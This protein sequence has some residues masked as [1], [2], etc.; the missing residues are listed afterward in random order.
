MARVLIVD[1]SA[2]AR[3]RLA[4]VLK[5]DGHEVIEADSGTAALK[6]LKEI[7]PDLVTV[8]LLMP[9]MDGLELIRKIRETD[10]DLP[11]AVISAD[12]QKA[13][14]EEVAASGV[15]AFFPKTGDPEE[16]LRF[17]QGLGK[18]SQSFILS[19]RQKDA[20]T[21]MTN[22]AMGQ[23]ASA[24]SVLMDKPVK[25]RVPHLDIM[26]ASA[27]ETFLTQEITA[28]GAVI[29][30]RFSGVL[31]GNASL[32]LSLDDALA[33]VRV[34]L[35][36]QKDLS[37]LSSAEQ[38]VLAEVGNIVL[39]SA[40]AVLGDQMGGRLHIAL[41]LVFLSLSS[42]VL[43]EMLLK[44]TQD[45]EQAVVLL[46]RLSIGSME[47]LCYLI[48]IMTQKQIRLLLDKMGV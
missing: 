20:F 7:R 46:S 34:L 9:E 44:D 24:L 6:L 32:V 10:P 2:F 3:S 8:D 4:Q 48:L 19:L 47:L 25:I 35:G 42:R 39:N 14:R 22:L 27:L 11:L 5:R 1:D 33:L 26:A 45:G 30:Q 16:L 23:A 31:N 13:S 38:T 17:V 40:L 29:M 18:E 21:E 12:V 36:T 43:V 37:Q 28:M 15:S 41:P